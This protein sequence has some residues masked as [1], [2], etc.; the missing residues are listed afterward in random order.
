MSRE[1]GSM[2]HLATPGAQA[3]TLAVACLA[4]ASLGSATATGEGW[5]GWP[6]LVWSVVIGLTLMAGWRLRRLAENWLTTADNDW[7]TELSSR[8]PALSPVLILMAVGPL[9]WNGVSRLMGFEGSTLEV[10]LMTGVQFLACGLAAASVWPGYQPLAIIC[11]LFSVLFAASVSQERLTM[12]FA[13]VFTVMAMA[14]LLGA[15]WSAV[16][17]RLH[18]SQAGQRPRWTLLLPLVV[19]GA[20]TATVGLARGDRM[21]A[22]AGFMNSS[23]GSGD[24]DNAARRGVGDGDALVAGQ[25]DIKSFGPIEDAPF[26]NSPEPSLYDLYNDLY[27][28]PVRNTKIDRAIVLPP[29]M[30][31][32]VQQRMSKSQIANRE[33]STARGSKSRSSE[34]MKDLT[35]NAL[36]YVKGRVPLH[37]RLELFDIF[38]G[39]VWQGMEPGQS[40]GSD[41]LRI[42]TIGGRPWLRMV[43]TR[44]VEVLAKVETH[45]LKVIHLKGNRVPTPLHV[46]GLHIDRLEDAG[47]FEWVGDGLVRMV[48]KNLPEL[49][50]IHVR[51]HAVDP[52]RVGGEMIWG[53][54]LPEYNALPIG[55][56]YDRIKQ[57]AQDWTRG[58]KRGWPQIAA[59]EQRLKRDYVLDP[60]AKFPVG[61]LS[62]LG[63]FLFEKKRGPDYQFATA[64]A[65]LLRSLG[66]STRLVGGFYASPA[67]FDTLRQHTPVVGADA[68]TWTEVLM[69]GSTWLTV[70]A[71]PGYEV[72]G[73]PPTY[74]DHL[75]AVFFRMACWLWEQKLL[76]AGAVFVVGVAWWTRAAWMDHG[77][78]L[79]WTWRRYES[80]RER[81]AAT[82]RLVEQ[83]LARLQTRRMPGEP[84][85]ESL[86]RW[87]AAEGRAEAPFVTLGRL[88]DWAAFAPANVAAP[89]STTA[90]QG[91]TAV[92]EEICRTCVAAVYERPRKG[93]VATS[94]R[95]RRD[96]LTAS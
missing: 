73:P 48:R 29:D 72:L 88:A 45:A 14:W 7:R 93:A 90:E 39:E 38:D 4:A 65:M 1:S 43:P 70:E 25:E 46:R 49:T 28:E 51:S 12:L 86:R 3:R 15:Y 40:R 82:L 17:A 94:D 60:V 87:A 80:P 32:Q 78:K 41:A 96:L 53:R 67:R 5:A 66:Y 11:S 83:R 68:H 59:I 69:S 13:A 61:E 74:L 37:L 57:L 64:A 33:F 92:I 54:S 9:V 58:V 71:T 91:E 8:G 26:R 79:A 20:M 27:D 52:N 21:L 16:I 84:P 10:D 50:A 44:A 47:L 22:L 34:R 89:V 42:E 76:V 35:S 2:P 75:L 31:A 62:P 63:Q 85:V 77:R 36:L 19:L 55:A 24:Q 95:A 56:E 18:G 23:G 30:A 6:W 81:V